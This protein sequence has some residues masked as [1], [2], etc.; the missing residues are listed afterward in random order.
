MF[1]SGDPSNIQYSEPTVFLVTGATGAIGKAIAR[2]LAA[3]PNAEVVLVCR[4]PSKAEQAV[5]EITTVTG[6]SKVRF[7]LAD[8]SS[9]KDIQNLAKRWTGPLHALINN[10]AITPR[11]R[12]ETAEGIEMQFATNVLGYF[13]LVEAFT[14]TL[15]ASAPSRIVNVASYWA[16]GLDLNDLEFTRRRYDNDSAYRQ[17]KQANRMLTAAFAE[18]LHP[19]GISVNACHP[20]DVNS[21]LSN[22]LGFG[23]HEAPD[24]GAETPVWLATHPIGIETTGRYYEHKQEVDCGY[25][26]DKQAIAALYQA[27]MGYNGH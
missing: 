1:P 23:G 24:Q 12:Q 16:G 8:L 26:R 19:F 11:T 20:G 25:N 2:Q 22:E 7:E 18:K 9:L 3:K 17:S 6:N 27:Y 15:K 21:K 4:N 10:A 14:D 5:A 13:W